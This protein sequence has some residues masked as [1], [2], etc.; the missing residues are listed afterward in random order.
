MPLPPVTAL[1]SAPLSQQ[2]DFGYA[3]REASLLPDLTLFP[4]CTCGGHRRGHQEAAKHHPAE[5]RDG[6]RCGDAESGHTPGQPGVHR[7]EHQQQQLGRHVRAARP[8]VVLPVLP[9]A[10]VTVPGA[11]RENLRLGF[12]ARCL[13]PLSLPSSIPLPH[14]SC[15]GPIFR[16]LQAAGFPPFCLFSCLCL[17]APAHCLTPGDRVQKENGIQKSFKSKT[18][19]GAQIN[20][21]LTSG[22]AWGLGR[23]SG[24]SRVSQTAWGHAGR[25]ET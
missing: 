8:T 9:G 4:F 23:R 3:L 1:P 6:H 12:P 17:P 13:D 20:G 11:G 5:H 10:L 24:C 7:R 21:V 25:T 15:L 18:I 22:L 2:G 19:V 14:V 16:P